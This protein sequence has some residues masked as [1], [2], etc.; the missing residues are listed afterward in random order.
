MC[1]PVDPTVP[2]GPGVM[3]SFIEL[4]PWER[5]EVLW[6]VSPHPNTHS[7]ILS[8]N[9]AQYRPEDVRYPDNPCQW[10]WD[11]SKVSVRMSDPTKAEHSRDSEMP[12]N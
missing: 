11:S 7:V 2:Y 4:S 1:W 9:A 5:D 10:S 8:Q 6:T 3:R 12:G